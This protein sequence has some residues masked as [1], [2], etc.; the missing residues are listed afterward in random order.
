MMMSDDI[1]EYLPNYKILLT[2]DR[3][4]FNLQA[5]YAQHIKTWSLRTKILP[6]YTGTVN[7]NDFGGNIHFIFKAMWLLNLSIG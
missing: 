6:S 2:V 4:W 3:Y 1:L 7:R 5:Y